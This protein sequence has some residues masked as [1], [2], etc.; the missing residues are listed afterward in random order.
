MRAHPSPTNLPR[1]LQERSR[2]SRCL[3]PQCHIAKVAAKVLGFVAEDWPKCPAGGLFAWLFAELSPAEQAAATVLGWDEN[4]W[5]PDTAFDLEDELTEIEAAFE[6][7]LLSPAGQAPAEEVAPADSREALVGRARALLVREAAERGGPGLCGLQVGCCCAQETEAPRIWPK[8]LA[9]NRV[10]QM[11]DVA[12]HPDCSRLLCAPHPR[13]P[14]LSASPQRAVLCAPWSAQCRGL[15]VRAELVAGRDPAEEYAG[16]LRVRPPT[17][18]CQGC[19][20]LPAAHC[21]LPTARCR[22]ATAFSCRW[23]L[24]PPP[25]AHS[26]GGAGCRQLRNR[27]SAAMHGWSSRSWSRSGRHTV[28]RRLHWM[29]VT[30]SSPV[31]NFRLAPLPHVHSSVPWRAVATW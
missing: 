2:C 29:Q 7:W 1:I 26:P 3:S 21:P 16:C 5:P 20:P 28:P 8:N 22:K 12:L 9:S 11:R 4:S 17:A 19:T 31:G 24:V 30:P 18:D 13:S 27:G 10:L 6:P 15:L 23:P 25:R 14:Q